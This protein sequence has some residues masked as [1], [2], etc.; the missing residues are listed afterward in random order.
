MFEF[1]TILPT[2]YLMLR[3]V[4]RSVM[5][6]KMLI[7]GLPV[8]CNGGI[9][10]LLSDGSITLDCKEK[11]VDKIEKDGTTLTSNRVVSIPTG[12]PANKFVDM[13]REMS[14]EDAYANILKMITMDGKG[15]NMG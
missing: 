14:D 8:T 11:I 9:Y 15:Q 5:A 2:G 10:R 6:L 12:L 1:Y 4:D 3:D 7:L 13:F